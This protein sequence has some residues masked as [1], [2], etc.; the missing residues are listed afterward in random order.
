MSESLICKLTMKTVDLRGGAGGLPELTQVDIAAGLSYLRLTRFETGYLRARILQS[1]AWHPTSDL[2]IE[3]WMWAKDFEIREG[4]NI[5][6]GSYLTR[7][8]SYLA[9][10]LRVRP[11]QCK[12]EGCKG[13]GVYL[14]KGSPVLAACRRC[15]GLR[16]DPDSGKMLGNG[17]R[18]MSARHFARQ[19]EINH[20]TFSAT[21]EARLRTLTAGLLEIEHKAKYLKGVVYDS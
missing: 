18:R 11:E 19:L 3:A 20:E 17:Q 9:V 10:D 21:W 12:C 14:P 1:E 8:L 13:T 6:R 2:A 7:K 15:D 16:L 4:W 5:P